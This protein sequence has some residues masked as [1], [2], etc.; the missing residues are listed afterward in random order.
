MIRNSFSK[1]LLRQSLKEFIP[2]KEELIK[3]IGLNLPFDK[4]INS[5][6][7]LWVH[8]NLEIKKVNF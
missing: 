1:V 7:K 3:K 2:K 5:N 6:L 8:E 4:W